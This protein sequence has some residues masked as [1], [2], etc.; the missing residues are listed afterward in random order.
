MKDLSEGD[1]FLYCFVLAIQLF[2]VICL[3]C[4]HRS[5]YLNELSLERI[6][7]ELEKQDRKHE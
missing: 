5:K 2:L 1:L 6:E 4:V 7:R 3:C